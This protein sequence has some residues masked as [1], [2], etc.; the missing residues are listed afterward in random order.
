MAVITMQQL[1]AMFTYK[2]RVQYTII[3]MCVC[4]CVYLLSFLFSRKP[5]WYLL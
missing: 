1:E 5:Y 3:Y 2:E 4:V